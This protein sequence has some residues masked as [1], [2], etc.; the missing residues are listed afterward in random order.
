MKIRYANGTI[1]CEE[2]MKY[3]VLNRMS[4]RIYCEIIM[5]KEVVK[6]AK[7]LG[8]QVSDEQL[9]EFSDSYRKVTGLQSADDTFNY[10]KKEGLT[11]DDFEAYCET[12]ILM[13][14][15][16]DHLADKKGM[17]DYFYNHRSE[18]DQARISAIFVTKEDLANEIMMQVTEDGED[19]HALARKYS[20]D[21]QT[22]YAGGYIGIITRDRLSSEV[23]AKVFNASS[24]DLLGPFH[25]DG[26]FQLILIEEIMKADINDS[27]LKDVIKERIF[28]EWVSQFIKQG[29][30]VK[31]E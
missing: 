29:I 24:G 17:E 5:N 15:I 19:F 2:V 30:S 3:L 16:K 7:D 1:S 28:N 26:L 14:L 21:E 27:T 18:L 9:Q 23:A 22:R 20:V 8:I 4:F 11:L 31:P 12:K 6:K 25:M 13:D 10:L